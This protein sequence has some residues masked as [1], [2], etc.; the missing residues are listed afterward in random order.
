MTA[1]KAP[2]EGARREKGSGTAPRWDKKRQ[3]WTLNI[4]LP[5]GSKR[6]LTH[7]TSAHELEQLRDRV[8]QAIA[9]GEPTPT[10]KLTLGVFLDRWIESIRVASLH[11]KPKRGTWRSYD[12]HVRVH[13]KPVLGDEP[14][15]RLAV[16]RVQQFYDDKIAAG[17]TP[18]NMQR[19]NATLRI[20]LGRALKQGLVTRNVAKLVEIS[21]P[22]NN[23]VGK[24]LEPEQ[25]EALQAAAVSERHGPMLTF[26][27]VTGLRLG[28][29]QALRW[30]DVN[31]HRGELKVRH[32]LEQLPNE[33]WHL[34]PPKSRPSRDRVVPLVPA[35]L[36]VLRQQRDRQ[37]F[38]SQR[39]REAWVEQDF[40]FANEVGD[41]VAQRGVQDAMKRSLGR[42]GLDLDTRVHDLR[43]SACT[44]L[45]AMGIPL[46]TVQAIMGHSTLVMT[47]RYTHVQSAM[48][49]D[50][51]ARMAAFFAGLGTSMGTSMGAF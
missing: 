38:E 35:A 9:N 7:K 3:R 24:A 8:L 43:H 44:F 26:L 28:E 15:A 14:L 5:D 10:A 49:D 46:P 13:L 30:R 25:V 2:G 33:P 6:T 37:R 4:T 34:V 29:A 23:R 19:V 41:V 48:L 40:V 32:T 11:G 39:A 21:V 22:D 12:V 20:A 18:A 27:V 45:I 42:A 36:E 50:A 1:R 47:E 31:D 17:A 51:K 16:Q